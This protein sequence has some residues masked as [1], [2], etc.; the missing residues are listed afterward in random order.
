MGFGIEIMEIG[1]VCAICMLSPG[2]LE[3]HSLEDYNLHHV[4]CCFRQNKWR[5]LNENGQIKVFY[6]NRKFQ[7]NDFELVRVSVVT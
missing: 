2:S 4:S 5:T 3:M 6:E 1:K 7:F